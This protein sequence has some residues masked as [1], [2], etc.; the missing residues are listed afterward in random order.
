MSMINKY[1]LRIYG[2]YGTQEYL[3]PRYSGTPGS[4]ENWLYGEHEI[5]SYT[6]E[7]CSRRPE[8]TTSRVLDACWKHV[9]VNLY[10]CERSVNIEQEKNDYYLNP[11][12]SQIIYFLK[13][14][15]DSI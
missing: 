5:I 10:I 3:I 1:K 6:I 9:G 12:I 4:S 11:I 7:L 14:L 2:Q 13:Q 8:R 15:K